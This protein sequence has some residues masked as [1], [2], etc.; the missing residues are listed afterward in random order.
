MK[1]LSPYSKLNK[2]LQSKV[3]G[4]LL[5]HGNHDSGLIDDLLVVLE[6]AGEDDGLLVLDSLAHLTSQG[7]IVPGLWS[8]LRGLLQAQI[9]QGKGMSHFQEAAFPFKLPERIEVSR[10]ALLAQWESEGLSYSEEM[11]DWE[12]GEIQWDAPTVYGFKK[13]T[14]PRKVYEVLLSGG[15][16]YDDFLQIQ[17]RGKSIAKATLTRILRSFLSDPAMLLP[18]AGEL[19]HDPQSGRLW[20]VRDPAKA[21]EESLPWRERT[22]PL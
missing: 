14:L 13:L 17:V 8:K 19:L 4:F 16:C 15:G 9:P 3:L 18:G 22:L 11:L 5:E 2:D 10:E 12:S 21:L 1:L 6:E 7:R 20:M